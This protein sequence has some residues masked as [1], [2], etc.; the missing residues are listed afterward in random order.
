VSARSVLSRAARLANYDV[1]ALLPIARLQLAAGDGDGAAYSVAK[2][3]QGRPD[4]VAAMALAVDVEMRRGDMARADTALNEL[5]A[6]HPGRVETALARAAVAM[7]RGQHA[8]AVDAYRKAFSL[9]ESSANALALAAAYLTAGDAAKA[10]SL[11]ESWVDKR[12]HDLVVQKAQA[13]AQF[14]AGQLAAARRSYARVVAADPD[15]AGVLNNYANLL[16]QL[17]DAGASDAARKALKLAPGNALYGDTLGW[18]LVQQGETEAGLRHLRE[19]RLRDPENGEIRFHLA[20]ALA[21]AGRK[22]EARE[23]LRAA[24]GSTASDAQRAAWRQLEKDLGS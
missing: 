17:G 5:A 19:A 21:K 7:S 11:L 1:A 6:K 15:D 12:P 24:L 14:R 16:L 4:D 20:H 13:E 18:I 9:E 2:A 23:E 3:L 22:A 10:A 8:Q